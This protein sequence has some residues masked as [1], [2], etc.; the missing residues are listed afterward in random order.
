MRSPRRARS[1]RGPRA[2]ADDRDLVELLVELVDAVAELLDVVVVDEVGPAQEQTR[3]HEQTA[4]A[5]T[6][7]R[8]ERRVELVG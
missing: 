8:G 5:L 6:G 1:C 2:G 3:G 7:H 4:R